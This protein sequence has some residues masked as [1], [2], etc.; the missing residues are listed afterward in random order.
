MEMEKLKLLPTTGEA[1]A[2]SQATIP[3]ETIP[4][5]TIPPQTIRPQEVHQA[6][7]LRQTILPR[8]NLWRLRR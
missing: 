3:P 5:E 8:P 6:T 7:I 2:T 1:V 4:P